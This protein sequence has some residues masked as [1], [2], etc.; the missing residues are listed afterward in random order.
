MRL[1]IVNGKNFKSFIQISDLETQEDFEIHETIKKAVSRSEYMPFIQSLN[2]TISYSYLYNDVFV[3]ATFVQE[4]KKLVKELHGIDLFIEN[5]DSLIDNELSRESFDEFI[6]SLKVPEKIKIDD[7]KYKFQQDSVYELLKHRIGRIEIGTSGGKTFITYMFCRYCI[8]NLV[9]YNEKGYAKDNQKILIIVPSKLL[10]KQLKEDFAEYQ[11]F[12]ER[13]LIVETIYTGSK[14]IIDADIVCGTYQSLGNYE[15]EYFSEYRFII[16]DEVH[17]AKAY[18]IREEIYNKIKNA[19]YFFGMSG[20]YPKYKSLDYIHIV[21]MYGP[22]LYRKTIRSL[23]DDGISTPINLHLIN[24]SYKE[25]KFSRNLKEQG[26]IGTEKFHVEKDY[27]Q[28]FESRTELICKL[29]KAYTGNSLILVDTV[30][31]CHVL[32]TY[33]SRYFEN[34]DIEKDIR[35]IHGKISDRDQIISDMKTS[36]DNFIL[37]GTYGTMSTGVSIPNMEAVYFVDGGKSDIRIRQSIGRGIRL[38]PKTGKTHCEIFD[39]I[40]MMPL[41]SFKNHGKER[42]S[43]YREQELDFKETNITLDNTEYSKQFISELALEQ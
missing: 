21:S 9:E 20:T 14:K 30:E 25:N 36:Q 5:E 7:E 8:Q 4:I 32:E 17:R 31:Y 39:F 3:P 15:E 35:I 13:K 23:I 40:D 26:I 37:I 34:L 27:F 42:I 1:K 38:S 11:Q 24:I 16:C 43:I 22:L 10:A 18:T 28:G 29:L 19:E 6:K 12:E 2:K 41:S 33:I